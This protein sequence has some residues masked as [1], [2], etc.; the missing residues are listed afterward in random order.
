MRGTVLPGIDDVRRAAVCIAGFVR[1]TPVLRSASIDALVG[2]P[3]WFKCEHLQR[4][5]AFKYRGA[6]NAVQALDA[7]T[8]AR[9]VAAHS[10]GN[11]AAALAL[12]AA[13]RGIP[14]WV[15]MPADAPEVK[16]A[17]TQAHGAT[18]VLCE[19]TLAAREAILAE[20]LERTGAVEIHPYD[21]PAVI[22]GQ[23]TATLELLEQV[24]S[25][26]SVVAPVSGGGLLGGT[27]IAA[28]GVDPA[29]VVVGAEPVGVDDARRSLA[30]G[31]LV[32][33]HNTTSIADGLLAVLSERTLAILAD[34]DVEIVTVTEEEI[35]EA[36]A[37][38]FEA[39]K[40][41][42]EPSAAVAFAAVVR[43]GRRGTLPPGEV[44][45]ILSGGN[46]DLGALPFDRPTGV[47]G[48]TV[49]VE[50]RP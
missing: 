12:A 4:G 14:C 9:G 8:A 41:V 43:A 13:T 38:V 15:V 39:L 20:V 27:A 11:H 50:V 10:S 17:A 25:V 42:V 49:D 16:R 19:P 32:T 37:V 40:Q 36:M 23:G 35:I 44:G 34:H 47:R 29:I 22:A 31:R 46:V 5:G 3:V 1:R 21:H 45:V 28:H 48:L 2:R 33:E 30:A 26:R 6:T 24:P 18:V 7:A